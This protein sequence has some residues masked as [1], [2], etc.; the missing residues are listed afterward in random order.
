MPVYKALILN[1]EISINYEENEKQKLVD[2][3]KAINSKLKNYDYLNGKITDS[4]ILSILAIKL[5]VE[6][7]DFNENTKNEKSF[8][9]KTKELNSENIN[10][11]DKILKLREEN[12]SLKNENEFINN[13]LIEIQN[14]IAIITKLIKETYE[15]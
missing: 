7:F 2:S 12:I 1:K 8:E 13:E 9:I 11:N 3:I 10:L 6:I 5:Q 15:K 4:K 14:Q